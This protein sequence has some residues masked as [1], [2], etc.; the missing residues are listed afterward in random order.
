MERIS[1]LGNSGAVSSSVFPAEPTIVPTD[2]QAEL[3]VWS[4]GRSDADCVM[5][6]HGFSLDHT[7]WEPVAELLVAAG[8]RVVVPDLRGH[9]QSTLGTAAPTSDRLAD[10][11]AATIAALQLSDVHLVGHSLGAVVALTARTSSTLAEDLA[12]VTSVAGTERSIQNPV[13]KLGARLFSS[14]I[15]IKMLKRQ[16]AGRIMIS[17]WFG[18]NP[19]PDQLD[20]IRTLC[21]D[22]LPETRRRISEATGDVDLRVSFGVAGPPTFVMVGERDQATSAKVSRRI[23]DAIRGA[24]LEVIDDAGHMVIIER[25][26]AVAD[27]LISWIT[28]SP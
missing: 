16:R 4:C 3:A 7:T 28:L 18:K 17:T 20:W 6:L 26:D 15:G 8:Y 12:S 21:A 22:C 10:D 19:D 1:K 13:M 24:E 9:G 5:L 14:S 11:V 25:P 2:D 23:A 27:R